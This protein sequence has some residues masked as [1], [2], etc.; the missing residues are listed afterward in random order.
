M[1]PA[2]LWSTAPFAY[3]YTLGRRLVAS[4]FANELG[5]YRDHRLNRRPCC[6]GGVGTGALTGLWRKAEN[7]RPA[8]HAE[9]SFQF[10]GPSRVAL[11]CRFLVTNRS[12]SHICTA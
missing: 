11:P 6:S 5:F 12:A 3:G 9:Q 4:R 2:P 10:P 7:A 1:L 8:V